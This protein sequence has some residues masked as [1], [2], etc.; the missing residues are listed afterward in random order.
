[1]HRFWA[2]LTTEEFCGLD[3]ETT[4][5]V[6]PIA[7]IEQHGP[8]LP[9][10]TDT[11]IAH[12]MV[13]ETMARLPGRLAKAM[14]VLFLPVQ[15]I[16]KSNEHLRSPGTLTLSAETAIRGWTE[17]GEGVHR[18]GLRKLVMVN[19]HGG[20]VD[21]IS[22]V[23]RE[24]RVRLGMLAVACQ[25]ARFGSPAGLYT[26]QENAVGIHAGDME[27]SM[28]LHFR[29]DLVKMANAINFEPTTLEI[30]KSF[31]QLRPTGVTAF[32]WMAQDLHA[33][34]AAGNAS[35]ATAEKG[36]ATA[37]FRAEKFIEL[38]DDVG[39][40]ELQRLA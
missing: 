25:W 23:A 11:E 24:L 35:R 21:V 17:I 28:M 39:R 7:A 8:H 32:G 1:M 22:I 12:G 6:L 13:R 15:Q 29:P 30:A 33:A 3:P 9:V 40:F 14:T 37:E 16:G 18:A 4:I 20:N 2:D 27:T 5:A 10:S 36:R 31:K 26:E 38:L 34:G 19:S